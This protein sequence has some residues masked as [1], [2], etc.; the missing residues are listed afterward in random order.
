GRRR[1][2]R[3]G[4]RPRVD[5]RSF[6]GSHGRLIGILSKVFSPV[7]RTKGPPTGLAIHTPTAGLVVMALICMASTFQLS[8]VS[9]MFRGAP[10]CSRVN[11]TRSESRVPKGRGTQTVWTELPPQP[12]PPLRF[13]RGRVLPPRSS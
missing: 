3:A 13:T 8:Y 2:T 9:Q 5:D 1:S 6:T 7:R 11:E 12:P 10:S 4:E